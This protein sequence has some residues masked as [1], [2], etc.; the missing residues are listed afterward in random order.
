VGHYASRMRVPAWL[1]PIFVVAA[2]SCVG[3]AAYLAFDWADYGADST[4]GSLVH[5]K[6]A[7]EPCVHTMQG[8]VMFVVML[9][10]A[11]IVLLRL[12]WIAGRR[13][14]RI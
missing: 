4:C 10:L 8:R 1:R 14:A 2:V 3:F 9:G 5:Y 6:G 7:G 13:A 12:A 11:A